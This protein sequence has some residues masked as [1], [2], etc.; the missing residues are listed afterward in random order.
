[1]LEQIFKPGELAKFLRDLPVDGSSGAVQLFVEINQRLK[2][3]G[4]DINNAKPSSQELEIL[5]AACTLVITY[6][7][8]RTDLKLVYDEKINALGNWADLTNQMA[9]LQKRVQQ[10]TRQQ[11][12]EKI[13]S[14]IDELIEQAEATRGNESFGF[15]ILN[16][17]DRTR[18]FSAIE[19]LRSIFEQSDLSRK[20]K[21][22]LLAKLSELHKEAAREFTATERFFG[23][24]GDLSFVIGQMAKNAKPA[25]DEAKDMARIVM[26][27]RGE[28][29]GVQLPAPE[30]LPQLPAPEKD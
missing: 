13:K 1:M 19:K 11:N 6:V 20:K 23:F 12:R 22:A 18:I 2:S 14:E 5:F 29:E 17:D 21:D 4:V 10:T 15:A 27:R 16:E 25:I 26:N 30:D 3:I 24:L 9:H 8:K 28:Q 7:S